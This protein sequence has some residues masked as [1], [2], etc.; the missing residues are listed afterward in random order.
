MPVPRAL[1]ASALLALPALAA[2]GAGAGAGVAPSCAP[3]TFTGEATG[4]DEGA[5]LLVPFTVPPG[6]TE[7]KVRY[8]WSQPLDPVAS[9]Y[10]TTL[11]LGLRDPLG[12]RGWSGSGKGWPGAAL[13]V[14]G[15]PSPAGERAIRVG[16]DWATPSYA[17]GPIVP[18]EWLVEI[19]V[20]ALALGQS[21][22][23]T[24]EVACSDA[25]P[26]PAFER[27][28][29]P[30]AVRAGPA[31]FAGDLHA[32]SSHSENDAPVSRVADAAVARGLDFVS[33]TDHNA[34]SQ[35]AEF[36]AARARQPGLLLLRGTEV[37]T[38]RG[39]ANVHGVDAW[40]EYRAGP[41]YRI[42]P[43]GSRSLAQGP[44]DANDIFRSAR[45]AGGLA[46]INHPSFPT[47][48]VARNVCRG[49]GWEF[50]DTDFA[51]VDAIEVQTGPAGATP[52]TLGAPATLPSA[53]ARVGPNPL[54]PGAILFWERALLAGHRVTAVGGSDDHTAGRTVDVTH[55]ALGTPTT[56]V[57]ASELSERAILDGVKR[58]HAYVRFWGADGPVVSLDA[59]NGA[60][61]RAIMGDEIALPGVTLAVAAEGAPAAATLVLVANG[62]PVAV[63]PAAAGPL[64]V[65]A[66]V[67]GFYYALVTEGSNVLAL[68]N[69][70]YVTAARS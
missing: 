60:G 43:D 4:A 49:C 26:G 10:R 12:F 2:A 56:V 40:K 32:H 47:D 59:R 27:A 39:H 61:E 52:A 42:E 51:L 45:A 25:P 13:D 48:P 54:T 17:P 35:Y 69:P 24:V 64:V 58:G 14:R 41:V 1:L 46:Q 50:A 68:T 36:A 5:Y 63:S 7:V 16:P 19:G 65:P 6:A 55:S 28:P 62:A 8:R 29:L 11:D 34:V 66:H 18:G 23:F 37:T 3:A 31:W 15:E 57:L 67:A 70:V 20:A 22:T 21:T 9:A 53:H 38:Y 30:G 44:L 33:L